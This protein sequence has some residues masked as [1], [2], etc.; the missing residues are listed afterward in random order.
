MKEKNS[1]F[2]NVSC[3]KKRF[4]CTTISDHYSCCIDCWRKSSTFISFL[5]V[6]VPDLSNDYSPITV[7]RPIK[8]C[9]RAH[10]EV[11][12]PLS[13]PASTCRATCTLWGYKHMLS[14]NLV[15]LLKMVQF[16]KVSFYSSARKALSS[17]LANELSSIF[18]ATFFLK[19]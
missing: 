9:Y 8:E 18:R 19:N 5:E 7:K 15:Q 14:E 4:N 17:C 10:L 3:D 11:L 2:D 6:L 13:C 1:H 12:G 16:M